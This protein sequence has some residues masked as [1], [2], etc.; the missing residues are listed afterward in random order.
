MTEQGLPTDDSVWYVGYVDEKH[1][2]ADVPFLESR[3]EADACAK[4]LIYPMRTI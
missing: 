2:E 1:D 4:M 3:T